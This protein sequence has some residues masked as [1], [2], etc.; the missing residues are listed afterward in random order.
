MSNVKKWDRN[1]PWGRAEQNQPPKTVTKKEAQIFDTS[2]KPEKRK[3]WLDP[4]GMSQLQNAVQKKAKT[5]FIHGRE[6]NL[7]YGI[8]QESPLTERYEVVKVKR[9]DGVLAPFGY[10]SLSRILK[11][12]FEAGE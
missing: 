10:V 6:Y 2:A 11:F 4:I 9:K 8:Y 5:A 12:D 3:D 7:T 1:D